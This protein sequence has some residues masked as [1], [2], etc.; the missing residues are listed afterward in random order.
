MKLAGFLLLIL[1]LRPILLISQ[2][3]I[4]VHQ[5]SLEYVIKRPGDANL[6]VTKSFTV[7]NIKGLE[8]A[9]FT[10]YH[11][12]FRKLK[13][14]KFEMTN[15]RGER[16]EVYNIRDLLDLSLSGYANVTDSRVY[17]LDSKYKK[18]PF[19]VHYTYEMDFSGFISLDDWQP[20]KDFNTIIEESKISVKYPRDMTFEVMAVL[21]MKEPETYCDD[22]FCHFKIEYK[23][24]KPISKKRYD[25]PLR[26]QTPRLLMKSNDFQLD[27]IDGSLASW[28]SFGDW[29]L[30]LNRR[31]EQI[32]PK[33]RS[34]VENIR[35]SFD[36]VPELVDSVYKYMQSRTRYISIQLGVGGFKS[37]PAEEVDTKGYGDC[38]ALTNYTQELLSIAGIKSYQVLVMAGSNVP[39]LIEDFPSNQFNHVFLAVPHENDTLWLECTS[40]TMPSDYLG[41]FT[42]DRKVLW[43]DQG[44][45]Q[46][47]KTP[48]YSVEQNL[49]LEHVKISLTENG[50]AK[51]EI[52]ITKG[53]NYFEEGQ[54][55]LYQATEEIQKS[56]QEKFS[57]SQYSIDHFAFEM[58]QDSLLLKEVYVLNVPSFAKK[59]G[60]RLVVD[61]K[62]FVK[63]SRISANTS[64]HF[65]RL[66]RNYQVV[67]TIEI[68]FPENH[69]L[70]HANENLSIKKEFGEYELKVKR[71]PQGV[72]YYKKL[73]LKKGDYSGDEFIELQEFMNG[74][75]KNEISKIML[76]S[77]T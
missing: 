70:Q 51:I 77:K 15:D 14:F 30:K 57:F 55:Y 76:S 73:I 3:N 45:S 68:I 32:T 72:Q 13:N 69:I 59:Y 54:S 1:L 38:K 67:Q 65:M 63:T 53:G 43:V 23:N 62:D 18:V 35:N 9:V 39:R 60:S 40:Q 4:T 42:D 20:I 33:T 64:D 50:H 11:D 26:D 49:V 52:K 5:E 10:L 31:D 48:Y 12:S 37:L 19:R 34:D 58:D 66:L 75:F 36:M 22:G 29:Y 6:K 24:I 28:K 17:L 46:I 21:G 44:N 47:V 8:S 2:A 71:S 74:V 41:S 27:G 16:I 61:M 25:E 7:H 56:N